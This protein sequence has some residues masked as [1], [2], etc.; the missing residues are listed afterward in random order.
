MI[1]MGQVSYKLKISH[2]VPTK[3][4][5]IIIEYCLF[6]GLWQWCYTLPSTIFQSYHGGQFYWWRKPEYPEKIIDLSRITALRSIA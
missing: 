6:V 4:L 2:I 5:I 1:K 3:Y